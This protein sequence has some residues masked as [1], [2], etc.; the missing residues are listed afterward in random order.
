MKI[1]RLPLVITAAVVVIL[2]PLGL[3]MARQTA[4]PPTLRALGKVGVPV[5][6]TEKSVPIPLD[7]GERRI[8]IV[9][10]QDGQG[11]SAPLA[12]S[13]AVNVSV[14]GSRSVACD[15]LPSPLVTLSMARNNEPIY[16]VA[17]NGRLSLRELDGRSFP[18]LE[19]NDIPTISMDDSKTQYRFLSFPSNVWVHALDPRT[20]YP[21]PLEPTGFTAETDKLDTRI[22]IV[23][24]HDTAGKYVPAQEATRVNIAVD[25]FEHGSLRSVKSFPADHI[26]LYFARGNEVIRPAIEVD[27][28]GLAAKP[29]SQEINRISLVEYPR[30]VFNDI[31]VLPDQQYNFLVWLVPP[32]KQESLIVYPNIWTHAKDARTYYPDPERPPTCVPKFTPTPPPVSSSSTSTS[33]VPSATPTAAY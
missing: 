6:G 10:P 23:F 29:P 14:W 5:T 18:S 19:Y 11:A 1:Q 7:W 25:I 3:T 30:W 31:P 22:Q 2:L 8:S 27:A 24:P 13:K 28:Q 16:Q 17:V 9:W 33:T 15:Q 12:V 21:Q 4:S 32:P 20:Y 26:I